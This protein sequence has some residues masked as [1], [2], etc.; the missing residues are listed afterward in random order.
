MHLP[1]K[2]IV[3]ALFLLV[4]SGF[5][6]NALPPVITVRFANPE[7]VCSTQTY[8]LD[9][10][11]QSNTP[12]KQLYGMNVRFYY[13]DDVLE[14]LSF[15]E[16]QQGY[17]PVI[18]NPPYI[19][20]GNSSS[21]MSY[22][23]FPGA[24]EFVNGAVQKVSS[25][26]IYLSTTG[27]TKLF[28][29]SFHVDDPEAFNIDSFTPC[30]IWDLKENP[31]DGGISGSAGV[32]ITIVSGT[33]SVISTE[34]VVQFNWQYDG[35]PGLPHGYPVNTDNI[36]TICDYAPDTYLP[37]CGIAEPGQFNLPVTVT[38]F[39]DIGAFSL[40]FEYDPAILT[41][42][43]N[44]P[45]D[46]FTAEN[47]LLTINDSASTGGK[48]KI[49]LSYQGN[50]ITL[51]D[52]AH[53]TDLYFNYTS[54]TT[55]FTWKTDS[56]SCQYADSNDI[57]VYDQP[58][59]DYYINGN[60]ANGEI[61][62]TGATSNDWNTSSNWINNVIPDQYTNITID[63]SSAP[64][65]WPSFTGNFTLGGQCKNL[66]L[67][68]NAQLSISGDLTIE[69]GHTLDI[70]GSG[71]LQI[72]GN[73]TNSGIFNPGSGIVEFA[74]TLDGII[75]EGVPPT[76]TEEVFNKLIISKFPGKLYIQKDVRV[77][78]LY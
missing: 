54:G 77:T 65:C 78:G 46:I 1:K 40:V 30:A 55:E 53:L 8:S 72:G 44:T 50:T 58:N 48:N 15:G 17:G 29:I 45:N 25:S 70:N 32:V 62:W 11:F 7:Y 43:N 20:T 10:E 2:I 64:S 74:G 51:S 4:M 28:N 66:T 27:W 35:V 71:I 33:G 75:A 6:A 16:F 22:F 57:P 26:S 3:P 24:Y 69:P 41:Y 38:N 76:N 59:S 73:W 68:G 13:A 31:G 61:I 5:Q 37:I 14:F 39:D 42:V 67:V 49:T 52:S 60:M 23:E 9:V 36:N 19:T 63:P 56:N 47:G 34:N 21:G 18:P 12:D